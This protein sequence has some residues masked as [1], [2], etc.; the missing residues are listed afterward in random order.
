MA[1]FARADRR[2]LEQL[3]QRIRRSAADP[4][5]ELRD[6]LEAAFGRILERINPLP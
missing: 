6:A 2:E 3:F 5:R 4:P 1:D